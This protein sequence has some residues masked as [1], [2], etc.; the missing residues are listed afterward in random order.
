MI[1]VDFNGIVIANLFANR[2]AMLDVDEGLIRHIVLNSLRA[3]NLKFR[4]EYGPMYIAC[5]YGSWR[6]SYMKEY[7]AN[8]STNREAS[9]YDWDKIFKVISMIKDELVEYSPWNVVEVPMCEADD[10]IAV[11]VERTQEFGVNDNVMIISN[12]KDFLQLQKYKNVKQFAPVKKK[13][14]T[15][16]DPHDYLI[17]HIFRG[18]TGDG[19]P[20]VL[21]DDDALCNPDK[22]QRMLTQKKID[23]WKKNLDKLE[24]VLPREVFR[25]YQR[26][27]KMVDLDHIPK[28]VRD[29]INNAIDRLPEKNNMKM[30]SYLI[31]H[32]CNMLIGCVD[33]FFYK[34]N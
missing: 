11:L 29:K 19:V 26:N 1:I 4:K 33:D 23:L 27:R 22:K 10:I 30:L 13:L 15:T 18:D 20:N 3:H 32:R 14:I 2:R 12:D 5:D 24:E 25:N 31:K 7:K 9:E 8:R 34:G 28:E 21:S 6:K 16:K 17:E